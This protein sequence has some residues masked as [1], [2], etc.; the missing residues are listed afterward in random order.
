MG[1]AVAGPPAHGLDLPLWQFGRCCSSGCPNPERVASVFIGVKARTQEK[2]SEE[3]IEALPGKEGAV[4][5]GRC[6]GGWS[7]LVDGSVGLHCI[8]WVGG[9]SCGP[10]CDCAAMAERVRFGSSNV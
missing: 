7:V 1:V 9:C 5:E 8:Y 4:L 10:D 6:W 3:V 2:F